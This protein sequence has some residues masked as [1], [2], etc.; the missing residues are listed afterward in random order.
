M[1]SRIVAL[2]AGYTLCIIVA[3]LTYHEAPKIIYGFWSWLGGAFFMALVFH[4]AAVVA[5]ARRV[6][7]ASSRSESASMRSGT[8]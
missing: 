4:Y 3:V 2:W 1:N 7:M 8:Q 5:V 6:R